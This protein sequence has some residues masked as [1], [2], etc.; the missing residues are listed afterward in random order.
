MKFTLIEI[1]ELSGNR[2]KIYSI[3]PQEYEEEG[4]TLFDEFLEE[5]TTEYSDETV[6]IFDRLKVMANITGI[7]DDFIKVNEGKPGDGICALYD[8]PGSKLR[9]YFIRF[10]NIA[11]VLGGG[12]HKPKNT[13]ALQETKKLKDANYLLREIAATL[14]LS[15]QEKELI[16]K[17]DGFQKN[18][19]T[20]FNTDPDDE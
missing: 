18:N 20:Y 11:I 2:L 12:G 16:I 14:S 19:N 15:I 10:G 4:Y 1:D 6:D 7:R 13:S 8:K 9:L 3:M 5:H 17:P